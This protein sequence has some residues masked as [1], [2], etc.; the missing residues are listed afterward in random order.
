[1]SF[2]N[3]A[4]NKGAL[5]RDRLERERQDLYKVCDC[6]CDCRCDCICDL[7]VTSYV[8]RLPQPFGP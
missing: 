8:T 1:M 3:A 5:E 4:N 7:V 2:N 6:I